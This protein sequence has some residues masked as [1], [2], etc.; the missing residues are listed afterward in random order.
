M[1]ISGG[2][3]RIA[4]EGDK[5]VVFGSNFNVNPAKISSPF[6]VKNIDDV[7]QTLKGSFLSSIVNAY[8]LEGSFLDDTL[9]EEQRTSAQFCQLSLE[10]YGRALDI[11]ERV[12]YEEMMR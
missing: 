12:N 8:Y 7:S 9:N 5:F 3:V 10:Q 4:K 11:Q 6:F 2:L 1:N